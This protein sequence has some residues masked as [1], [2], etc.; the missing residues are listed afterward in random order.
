MAWANTSVAAAKP[1]SGSTPVG[2]ERC[3]GD[4][5]TPECAVDT[6]FACRV[7]EHPSLCVAVGKTFD[8]TPNPTR[9]L[10]FR[11]RILS[12]RRLKDA[13]SPPILYGVGRLDWQPGDIDL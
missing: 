9:G 10:F 8:F 5:K 12:S 3:I 7:R 13:G 6:F 4:P 2:V 11:Y 1:T